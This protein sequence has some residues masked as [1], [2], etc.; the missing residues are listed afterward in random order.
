MIALTPGGRLLD[1]ALVERAR[2]RAGADAAVRAL[3]GLRRADRRS[4]SAATRCRSAATCSPAASWRRWCVCDAVLRKL[5]GALGHADSARR[6][7]LQRRARRR[8]RVPALHA[9][10]RVPR[11]DG[12]RRAALRP[13]RGD[14][15]AGAARA[16]ASA[17]RRPTALRYPDPSSRSGLPAGAISG[18]G[19]RTQDRIPRPLLAMSTV[20]ESLERAQLR[21]VPQLPA[22]R[23]RQG[24]LPGRRGHAPPHAGLRGRRHQAPGPR[25]AR[26]VHR[27]QAVVRRR[28]RAHVPRALAEDRADRGRRPR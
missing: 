24:P 8:S 6:G 20:I 9:P 28:R 19:S 15:R 17:A 14:P 13:P 25:R 26:D 22:R 21:R 23:P 16:A 11:L 18:A 1:D 12:A 7:V 5:P 2:G 3:R 27:P 4:T 10:G